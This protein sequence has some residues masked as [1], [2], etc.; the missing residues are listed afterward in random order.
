MG[1]DEK[2]YDPELILKNISAAKN[3][4]M[5]A[6]QYAQD[7]TY[8][9]I[10]V[11]E[12]MPKLADIF[13]RYTQ[14]CLKADAMD[15]DDL[16][17]KTYQL[18]RQYSAVLHKYQQRFQYIMI[19]EFQD[20][21]RVQYNI[22][23]SLTSQHQNIYIVGDD[24]QSIYGFRG[25][26]IQ[27]ILDF[28]KDYPQA[29]Q[30]KQEQNYRS[31]QNILKVANAIIRHNKSQIPKRIWTNNKS[32]PLL[33]LIKAT[34]ETEEADKVAH[35]IFT[36]QSSACGYEKFAVL[37]RTNKQSKAIKEALSK[38]AI[39]YICDSSESLGHVK[40]MTVHSAKGL[41]FPYVYIVGMIEGLFPFPAELEEERRLFY[42]A[43]TRA[44]EKV[45][46]SYSLSYFLYDCE[47]SCFIAE[48]SD[49][50]MR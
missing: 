30:I 17:L 44:R 16:L 8:Q 33:S 25:A 15:F 28:K 1:L 35:N 21:N 43:V 22:L 18:F 32:G 9:V 49:Y 37:Y 48:I 20:T 6:K 14:R 40:L 4:Q 11:M 39:P 50:F 5:T 41:E 29:K 24:A 7:P 12:G 45:T 47:P 23:K 13:S 3:Q 34:N 31:T 36:M 42:V 27:N 10:N 38:R 46:I 19:D 26:N 2:V